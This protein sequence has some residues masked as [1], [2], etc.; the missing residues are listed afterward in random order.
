LELNNYFNLNL[1]EPRCLIDNVKNMLQKTNEHNENLVKTVNFLKNYSNL[2][3]NDPLSSENITLSHL[4]L[5]SALN[6]FTNVF[7]MEK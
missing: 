2:N 7:H 6:C 4:C 1:N 5:N 3:M